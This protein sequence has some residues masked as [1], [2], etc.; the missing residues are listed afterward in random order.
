MITL[1]KSFEVQNYIGRL[2][3][4]GIS[5]MS[6]NDNMT[7][8]TQEHLRSKALA[9]AADETVV[10]PKS[11][12][13][14]FTPDELINFVW[15]LNKEREKLTSEINKAKLDDERT[16]EYYDTYIATNNKRRRLLSALTALTGIKKSKDEIR[17]GTGTKFNADGN[18]VSYL[19]DIKESTKI[20]F[21]RD[22]VVSMT[23]SLRDEINSYSEY[24]DYMQINIMVDY[25]YP[26]S[27]GVSFEEAI[28]EWIDKQA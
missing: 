13:Y 11:K 7:I 6:Y 17:H 22:N 1:K 26:L 12:E 3:E 24:I 16:E 23:Q 9:E 15:F 18:Q 21:N 10:K 8:T 5:I 27:V 4:E 19:Y 2:I 28:S 20:N 14:D 25:D